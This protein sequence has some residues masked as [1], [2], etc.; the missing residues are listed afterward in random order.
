MK[1]KTRQALQFLSTPEK[2]IFARMEKQVRSILE[3]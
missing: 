2:E 1:N 3:R